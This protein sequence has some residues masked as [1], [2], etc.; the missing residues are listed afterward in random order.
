M[1]IPREL[2]GD[3]LDADGKY[4]SVVREKIGV[5]A[6]EEIAGLFKGNEEFDGGCVGNLF[7]DMATC[8]TKDVDSMSFV[9]FGNM[10]EL[11]TGSTITV[12]PGVAQKTFAIGGSD[13]MMKPNPLGTPDSLTKELGAATVF[14]SMTTFMKNAGYFDRVEKGD[15]DLICMPT[16]K[17]TCDLYLK[18]DIL[19]R[20]VG[21][22]VFF[23]NETGERAI[24]ANP[25]IASKI[26]SSYPDNFPG[27]GKKPADLDI[28]TIVGA[29]ENHGNGVRGTC[30]A[31]CRPEWLKRAPGIQ[32]TITGN[33][34]K[35]SFVSNVHREYTLQPTDDCREKLT[36]WYEAFKEE[37]GKNYE[38]FRDEH[39]EIFGDEPQVE[40]SD[41]SADRDDDKVSD[42]QVPGD[43]ET[44]GVEK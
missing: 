27:H 37:V 7:D 18:G 20:S 11:C 36:E 38:K 33:E 44:L 30:A 35:F 6:L 43:D 8:H 28:D 19:V 15:N 2:E 23:T 17:P 4:P 21:D 26:V 13:T 42:E 40:T 34:V 25:F 39:P 9:Y 1:E 29:I 12:F 10:K 5:K 32:L 3:K 22:C 16:S 31:F 41:A 24:C 14:S